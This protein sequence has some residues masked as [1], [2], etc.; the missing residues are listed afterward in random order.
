MRQVPPFK[1]NGCAFENRPN[2]KIE[3]SSAFHSARASENFTAGTNG[4]E[5]SLESFLQIRK[6]LKFRKANQSTE[7]IPEIQSRKPNGTVISM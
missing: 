7:K 4:T 5:I 1:E 3:I 6:L 2:S